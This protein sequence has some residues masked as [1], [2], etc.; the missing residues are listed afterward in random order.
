MILSISLCSEG[1]LIGQDDTTVNEPVKIRLSLLYQNINNT[2]PRLLATVKTKVDRSYITLEDVNVKFYFGDSDESLY[3]GSLKTNDS[4]E[5]LFLVPETLRK[6]IDTTAVYLYTAA[7]QNEPGIKDKETDVEIIKS[8]VDLSFY[9]E[10]SI[11]KV[12]YQFW[13]ADSLGNMIPVEDLN[14]IFYIERLFG[15]LAVSGEFATTDEEGVCEIVF[16]DNLLGDSNGKLKV[17]VKIDD[18]D[19]Y[20]TIIA[21]AQ[22]DWG[23][24]L[25]QSDQSLERELWSS[26]ANAPIYLV[27]IVNA[28]LGGIVFTLI[29]II[30]NLY[31]IYTLSH[32]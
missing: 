1:I 6:I 4:G 21:K 17:L 13:T 5:A 3:L 15:L 29:Y 20:G 27:F 16:P 28:L 32:E 23:I 11:K 25:V 12:R 31:R 9:E 18:H 19:D 26:G 24:P 2:G 8:K 14:P 7:V 10:D 30:F 22:I